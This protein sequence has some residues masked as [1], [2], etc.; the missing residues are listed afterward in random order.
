MLGFVPRRSGPFDVFGG[1]GNTGGHT[2]DGAGAAGRFRNR[3]ALKLEA[4]HFGAQEVGFQVPVD[5]LGELW[6]S[7]P[8]H[9]LDDDEGDARAEKPTH[10]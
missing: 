2:A 4:V 6:V 5:G 7:V 9:L 8:E 10:S 3:H 1:V